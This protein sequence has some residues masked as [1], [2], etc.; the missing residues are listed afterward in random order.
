MGRLVRILV[1]DGLEQA[2]NETLVV[3]GEGN[4]V[5]QK[6]VRMQLDLELD[7]IE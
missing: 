7:G 1:G 3:S 5:A 6:A 2:V 4:R